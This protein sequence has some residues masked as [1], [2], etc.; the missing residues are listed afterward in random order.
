MAKK[1]LVPVFPSD[2]FY[3]A[4]VRAADILNDEG[5]LIVFA[6]THIRPSPD[7][8]ASDGDGRPAELDVAVD[9]GDFDALDLEKW[10]DAQIAGLEEARQLLYDRNIRDNQIDY[11]FADDA[12]TEG[13]AQANADEAAAGAYDIVVLSRGYFENEVDEPGEVGT[14]QEV[15]AAVSALEG[16]SLIVA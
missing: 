10:R 15:V 14:P 16:P 13:T 8:Y 3:E 9:A 7:A 11:V 6:F 1:V 12:D 4:V 5:G 2:R